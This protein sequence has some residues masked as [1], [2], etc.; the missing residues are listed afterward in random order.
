MR[1]ELAV[2]VRQQLSDRLIKE[3]HPGVVLEDEFKHT[4]YRCV[5]GCVSLCECV[6]LCKCVCVSLCV[7]SR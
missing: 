1:R 2:M 3:G 4:L 5:A 7:C 6:C